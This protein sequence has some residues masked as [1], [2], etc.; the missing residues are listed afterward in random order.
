[1][2]LNSDM[3][4]LWIENY[5]NFLMFEKNLSPLT[6]KAYSCDIDQFIMFCNHEKINS[7]NSVDHI[8]IRKYLGLLHS[9]GLKKSSMTRKIS[10]LSSFF[11]FL[12]KKE[13]IKTS[14]MIK[15][16][17]MKKEKNI[18]DF[19]RTAEVNQLLEAPDLSSFYGIRD[20][21]LLE[22]LYSSGLRVGELV[23]LNL[24][25]VNFK[26]KH[27][28]VF[29]KGAKERIVPIGNKALNSLDLYL[30]KARPIF[31]KKNNI[32]ENSLFLNC[33]GKRL[34]DRG[35]RNVINKYIKLLSYDKNVS[36]HTLRH[37]FATHLLDNG[38]DLRVVQDLLGHVSLSTTQIY[39]HVTS[40]KISSIYKKYHPRA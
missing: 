23:S 40:T 17:G 7:L 20:K 26:N 35:V 33:F 32:E 29:G 22:L 25:T 31:L 9:M 34:S 24:D 36:P 18:P 16:T 19:L 6:L 14:P 10:A 3:T 30:T 2:S 4:Q 1:M 13:Y 21:A 12:R 27:V 5:H 37:S 11:E 15:V 8:F 28:K 39:T 38:A